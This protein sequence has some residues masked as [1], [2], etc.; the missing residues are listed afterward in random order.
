RPSPRA[1]D[2]VPPTRS[3]R[4]PPSLRSTTEC[5]RRR[6]LRRR[7]AP[8]RSHGA[9]R[10]RAS[11]AVARQARAPIGCPCVAD[12]LPC[13]RRMSPRASA[14]AARGTPRASTPATRR[15]SLARRRE[16]GAASRSRR[17]RALEQH[18]LPEPARRPHAEPLLAR[19]LALA[20]SP[21][22]LVQPHAV[23]VREVLA[24]PPPLALRIRPRPLL[25]PLL[26][27]H[28]VALEALR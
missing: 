24:A 27:C 2:A 9:R 12:L 8:A 3:W 4:A 6:I 16:C 26:A 28:G 15:P 17:L 5:P 13:S 25:A 7:C 11:R 19:H 18:E 21:R 1:P 20:P 23:G 14:P 22:L 10:G